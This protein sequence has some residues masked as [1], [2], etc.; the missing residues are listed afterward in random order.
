VLNGKKVYAIIPVR[1]GSKG[2]P[3]KNLYK[4]NGV[5]IL[6][7]TIMLAQKCSYVDAILVS[8]DDNEMYEISKRMGVATK[9][10]RPDELATDSALTIDVLLHTAATEEIEEDAY[11]LLLQTTSPLR[12]KRDI[13]SLF[14]AFE[15]QKDEFDSAVSVTEHDDPHPNKIQKI[16]NGY[17]VSYLGVESMVP[18]QL[19]PNVYRLNGAFYLTDIQTLKNRKSFFTDKTMPFIFPKERSVNLDTMMDLYLLETIL[20][21]KLV[22]IE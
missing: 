1:G 5:S 20:E 22:E 12:I 21:K 11:I 4:I 14:E 17:V 8:T 3:G 6:E 19:L 7:R 16:E 2:I 18:R 15:R 9:E 13:D 10:K